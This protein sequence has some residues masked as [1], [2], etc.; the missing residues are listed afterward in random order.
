VQPPLEKRWF[1]GYAG[2]APGTKLFLLEQIPLQHRQKPFL[3][4]N[5]MVQDP[6]A[7]QVPCLPEPPGHILV[8]HARLKIAAGVVVGYHDGGCSLSHCL[9]EDLNDNLPMIQDYPMQVFVL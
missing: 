8:L 9:G 2:V 6:D 4:E 1:Y 5:E 3:S 7:Q